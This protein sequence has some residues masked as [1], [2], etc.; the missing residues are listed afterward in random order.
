MPPAGEPHAC[1]VPKLSGTLR[2]AVFSF[3]RLNCAAQQLGLV[4][5][6]AI[7]RSDINVLPGGVLRIG[8]LIPDNRS[9]T[10]RAIGRE[11]ELRLQLLHLVGKSCV[12]LMTQVQQQERRSTRY[13]KRKHAPKDSDIPERQARPDV[14]RPQVHGVSSRSTKPTPRTVCKSFF[15]KGS[16]TFRR[17]RAI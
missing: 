15:A 3:L 12:E 6:R 2:I 8:R 14:T 1:S 16:S 10:Q 11:A 7:E 9:D 13:V 4:K 17:S 5:D